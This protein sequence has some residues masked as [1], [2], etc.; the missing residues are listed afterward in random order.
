MCTK[1]KYAE[2]VIEIQNYVLSAFFKAAIIAYLIYYAVKGK[3]TLR[4]TLS[5]YF[6]IIISNI[7][8]LSAAL[9]CYCFVNIAEPGSSSCMAIALLNQNLILCIHSWTNALVVWVFPGIA[10]VELVTGHSSRIYLC[11]ALYAWLG[12]GVFLIASVILDTVKA[13]GLHPV[14][15]PYMCF[16]N[17]GLMSLLLF[18]GPIYILVD[19]Y[20]VLRVTACI[21]ASRSGH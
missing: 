18:T 13:P 16:I 8:T 14:Y 10:P 6:I 11:C 21:K 9:L 19:I 17:S 5:S 20:L 3:K 15:S 7:S 2:F 4:A 1:Y 12:P